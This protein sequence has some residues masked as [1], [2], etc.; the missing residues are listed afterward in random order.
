MNE[1]EK[2]CRGKGHN[3]LFS[4]TLI[5][6]CFSISIARNHRK[7]KESEQNVRTTK[8]SL[9]DVTITETVETNVRADQFG[10]EKAEKATRT[11]TKGELKNVLITDTVESDVR[12]EQHSREKEW[13]AT[14]R[15]QKL[16]NTNFD[17][18]RA[19]FN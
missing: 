2:S 8:A 12:K 10:R 15:Q 18:A 16:D 9:K 3:G 13:T 7:K 6:A 14:G 5:S 17:M 1:R 19:L 11:M 4:L